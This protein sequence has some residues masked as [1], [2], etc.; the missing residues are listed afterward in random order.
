MTANQAIGYMIAILQD[1]GLLPLIQGLVLLL[2]AAQA[3]RM[4]YNA[5]N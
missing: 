3:A 1:L 4:I 5:R 2:A